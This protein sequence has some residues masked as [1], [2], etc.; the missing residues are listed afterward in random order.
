MITITRLGEVQEAALWMYFFEDIHI[1]HGEEHPDD[2]FPG[3]IDGSTLTISD[4]EKAYRMLTDCANDRDDEGD[5]EFR[6]ALTRLATRVLKAA[7]R[8]K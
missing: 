1:E 7:Y 6:D 4:A 5:T 3:A 2:A 8:L